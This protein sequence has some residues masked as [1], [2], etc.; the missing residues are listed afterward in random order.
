MYQK[1]SCVLGNFYTWQTKHILGD[2]QRCCSASPDSMTYLN[3]IVSETWAV[4][5]TTC[6][7]PLRGHRAWDGWDSAPG[8][9]SLLWD[10]WRSL[11][12]PCAIKA[13][14]FSPWP[15]CLR[16]LLTLLPTGSSD[17]GY[18]YSAPSRNPGEPDGWRKASLGVL[19]NKCCNVCH[20]SSQ[21]W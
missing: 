21:I 3:F 7:G 5:M 20:I 9:G 11:P 12:P 8:Q 13:V 10:W 18:A 14:V 2:A 1:V 15:G 16:Q 6:P 4:L 19:T 17:M